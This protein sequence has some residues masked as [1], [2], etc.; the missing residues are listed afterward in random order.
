M[1]PPPAAGEKVQSSKRHAQMHRRR[2]L[3][4]CLLF[5]LCSL[6]LALP[7]RARL[8]EP[9]NIVWGSIILGATPATAAST[10]VVVE[11]RRTPAGP[12]FLS[13][14]MGTV[15]ALGDHYSLRLAM[16]EAAPLTRAAASLEGDHIFIVVTDASGDRDAQE[17]VLGGRGAFTQLDFGSL[18]SDHDGLPDAWE[19][20]YFGATG[21]LPGADPDHDGV[22]NL[23]EF[24]NGTNP[25][26]A[27]SRHPADNAPA[28]TQITIAEVTAYGSAWKRG[29]AWPTGPQ[30]GDPALINFV[31]RAGALWQGG[32]Y[33][34]QDTNQP[35]APLW[36][37]NVPPPATGNGHKIVRQEAPSPAAG[38]SSF[39]S[40]LPARVLPGSSFRVT[41]AV[42]L[43][44][45]V[46]A[47]AA[48][49][50]LAPGWLA[51]VI[52]ESGTYDVKSGVIRWGPFFDGE[53]R[54]FAFQLTAPLDPA[55]TVHAVFPG[56]LS[57]DGSPVPLGGRTVTGDGPATL[58]VVAQPDGIRIVLEGLPGRPQVIEGSSDLQRWEPLTTATPAADGT[59]EL[60]VA[61]G[62][63][64]AFYRVRPE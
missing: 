24:R 2:L 23:D 53:V 14:R 1:N 17:L 5:E 46:R 34:R 22:S 27:D 37:V 13:Y 38:G 56:V 52:N 3:S 8:A 30:P 12:A 18:D 62:G 58:A 49:Q 51:T 39:L 35:T 50:R 11:A 26:V 16:E 45:N 19:Q 64:A 33:Y 63:P 48:E 28:D 31:T 57:V 44:G 4:L 7:A 60:S 25:L 42:V 40:G 47:Y 61:H 20:Q 15:P 43:A 6:G 59:L 41:N 36:W 54:T 10:S 32:E 29:E 55:L 9:D 21:A